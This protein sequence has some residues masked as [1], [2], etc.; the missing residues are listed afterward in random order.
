[1]ISAGLSYGATLGATAA[2]MFPDRIDKMILDGVQNP[3]EYYHALANFQE[4]TGS[5]EAFSAIFTGCQS[6][7]ESCALAGDASAAE[8]E[9]KTWDLLDQVSHALP[10]P[11]GTLLVGVSC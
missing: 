4:W 9:Q 1:M 11:A 3:H 5:D 7:P 2:A 8:L 10:S 6:A